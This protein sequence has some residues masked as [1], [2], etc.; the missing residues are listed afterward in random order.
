MGYQF[1]IKA[2]EEA[3][4]DTAYSYEIQIRPRAYMLPEVIIH[5]L[6]TYE[7]FRKRFIEIKLKDDHYYVPGLP[8]IKPRDVPLLYD[9]DYIKHPLFAISSPISFFYYNFS[10]REKNKRLYYKLVAA[11]QLKLLADRKMNKAA[12]ARITGIEED[13]LDDFIEYCN[14]T[15]QMI[16]NTTEY[17]LYLYLSRKLRSYKLLKKSNE[18]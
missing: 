6:A 3:M 9:E 11:D 5:E 4:F 1:D 14:L 12:I 7:Q 13:D 15:P 16:L 18:E 10:R 8:R 17:E 2:V